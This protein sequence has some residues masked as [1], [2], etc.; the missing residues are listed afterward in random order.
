[1]ISGKVLSN[2]IA[3]LMRL[4]FAPADDRDAKA[5]AEEYERI[6]KAG[7]R[8]DATLIAAVDTAVDASPNVPAPADLVEAIRQANSRR[9]VVL[10][11]GCGR[12]TEGFIYVERGE[13]DAADFCAC[14]L[15]RWRK[16]AAN[17]FWAERKAEEER[18]RVSA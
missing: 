8:E 3:R 16:S 2:Q 15:G 6:L 11:E 17:R 10:P 18:R 4:P 5:L 12:C 1:M 14:A 9:F 7:C 13:Y